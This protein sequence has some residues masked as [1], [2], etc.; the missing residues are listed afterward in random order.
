MTRVNNIICEGINPRDLVLDEAELVARLKT[1]N[2]LEDKVIY[3]CLEKLLNT[4]RPRCCYAKTSVLLNEKGCVLDFMTVDSV[5]LKRALNGCKYAYVTAVTLGLEVDRLIA[6]LSVTN[7][8]EA[9]ITDAVASALAE[10][11]MDYVNGLFSNTNERFSVGY[12]DFVLSNQTK[13]LD[14][15]KADKHL[16]IKISQ[17]FIMT[18]RK[19]VTAIIGVRG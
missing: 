1:P 2:P 19:S 11:A 14:Y 13:I 4:S 18:P 8:A 15:L 10:S 16:G 5:S 17:K 12:G 6:T 9:F 3:E 7:K